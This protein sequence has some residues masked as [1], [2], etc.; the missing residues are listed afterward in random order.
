MNQKITIA[1][2][3]EYGSGG[4]TIGEMLAKDLGIAYYDQ[5]TIVSRASEDSGINEALFNEAA[6]EFKGLPIFG[7]TDVYQGE[8]LPPCD[9]DFTSPKNLFAYQAKVI[10]EMN[11][12]EPCIIVGHGCG[13]VLKN[14]PNVVRVFIHAPKYYLLEKASE[15]MSLRGKE[16]ERF[17]EKENKR[18][19]EYNYY[20][21]GEK[22][23]DAHHYDLCL[24][25][26]VLGFEKCVEM[27]KGYMKV[28]F[29]GLEL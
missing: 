25:S 1:I 23:D 8:L 28:R 29:E 9:K 18:R 24:N 21:T 16:L 6:T 27:I 11:E 20:Y 13:Y 15:R 26:S 2:N 12:T 22:W 14:R 7:G 17:V 3:R 5:R 10:K 4:R 19:A